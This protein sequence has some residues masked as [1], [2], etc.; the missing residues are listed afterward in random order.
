VYVFGKLELLN[1]HMRDSDRVEKFIKG[2][3]KYL[4][5]SF[6]MQAIS[7]PS[8]FLHRLRNIN[9][10][11]ARRSAPSDQS[12]VSLQGKFF[13][14]AQGQGGNYNA[15]RRGQQ[16][17][18]ANQSAPMI[19]PQFRSQ[20]SQDARFQ[21]TQGPIFSRAGRDEKRRQDT[22]TERS[23]GHELLT[24]WQQHLITQNKLTK[25]QTKEIGTKD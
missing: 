11:H 15:T 25:D 8:E 16:F 17:P 4:E 24:E 5:Q 14:D 13:Q 19:G 22:N 21:A 18:P 7:G 9:E 10:I 20:G 3:S 2:L 6:S 23:R 12:S 1:P